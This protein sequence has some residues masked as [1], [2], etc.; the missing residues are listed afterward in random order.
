M[1]QPFRPFARIFASTRRRMLALFLLLCLVLSMIFDSV[2][3]NGL[4]EEVGKL[5][6]V[7]GVG[8]GLLFLGVNLLRFLPENRLHRWQLAWFAVVSILGGA[9]FLAIGLASIWLY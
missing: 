6:G 7:F 1:L 3:D 2:N 8:G 5:F 9:L 4:W